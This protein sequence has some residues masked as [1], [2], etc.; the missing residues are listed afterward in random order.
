[1]VP[2]EKHPSEKVAEV[3]EILPQKLPRIGNAVRVGRNKLRN[4]LHIG[5]GHV[6]AKLLRNE[7]RARFDL[8]IR[9]IG[10]RRETELPVRQSFRRGPRLDREPDRP[11]VSLGVNARLVKTSGTSDRE[12]NVLGAIDDRLSL[13]VDRDQPDDLPLRN[14][15]LFPEIARCQLDRELSLEDG[16]IPPFDLSNHRAAHLARSVG[17]A[18]GRALGG[19]VVRLVPRVLP[20]RVVRKR[21]SEIRQMKERARRRRR[22]DERQIPVRAPRRQIALRHRPRRIERGAAKPEFVVR[23]LVAARVDRRP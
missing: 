13:R 1:M 5:S 4:D 2:F 9:E 12:N 14:P 10:E 15:V 22:L 3:V 7:R 20:V 18:T 19:V 6:P 8:P 11:D 23:L 17:A 21:N 16:D